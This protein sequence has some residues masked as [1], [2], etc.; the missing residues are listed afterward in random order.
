TILAPENASKEAT[1]ADVAKLIKQ[2]KNNKV[3]ALFV[4][5]ISNPRLIEQ[6][7]K[8]TGLKIGGILYSDALSEKEGPAA[9]YLDMMEHNV[10]TIINTITKR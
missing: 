7:S 4:E 8:E 2:I 9:T 10:N 6:I 1:A 3:S 5:N